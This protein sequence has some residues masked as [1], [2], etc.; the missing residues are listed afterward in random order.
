MPDPVVRKIPASKT[1]LAS[2][3]FPRADFADTYAIRLEA[4]GAGLLDLYARAM[5]E[6]PPA[7]V[8]DMMRLRDRLVA[9]FGIKT[10]A[11][12]RAGKGRPNRMKGTSSDIGGRIGAFT[13]L[14]RTENEILLGGNDRHLDFRVSILRG[15][16]G[17]VSDI[18]VTTVVKLNNLLGRFYL[19]P[20]KPAHR[21]I[22][23]A[24]MRRA[25]RSIFRTR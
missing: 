19:L 10:S 24:M 14:A 18:S 25:A 8:S 7:W 13:I 4:H 3:A 1:S 22:V 9:I 16:T 20:V 15:D 6:D 17:D 5:F 23:P 2:R 11:E 21:V 12:L